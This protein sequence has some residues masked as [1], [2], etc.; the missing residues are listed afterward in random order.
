MPLYGDLRGHG[1]VSIGADEV[2]MARNSSDH[3]KG[4]APM[5]LPFLP[6]LL[7][8]QAT[9]APAACPTPPVPLPAALSGWSQRATGPAIGRRF[10]ITGKF[11]LAGLASE[12]AA[13][14]GPAAIVPIEIASAGSYSVVLGD[15]AWIDLVQGDKAQLSSGHDHGPPCSGIRKI[16]RFTLAPGRYSLRLSGMRVAAIDALIVKN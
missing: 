10:T 9:P 1:K 11:G 4:L 16:V 3:A 6:L 14:P 13:R 8:L 5:I 2:Y 12:A 7:L 15:A